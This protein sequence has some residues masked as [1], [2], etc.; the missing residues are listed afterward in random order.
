MISY[1]N[2]QNASLTDLI[3]KSERTFFPKE[4]TIRGDSE[5]EY[6]VLGLYTDEKKLNEETDLQGLLDQNGNCS[7][8]FRTLEMRYETGISFI[9]PFVC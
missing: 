2:I 1:D 4:G 5:K 6:I 8:H 7:L 3:S 9:F